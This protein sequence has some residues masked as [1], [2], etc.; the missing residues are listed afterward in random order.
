MLLVI[1]IIQVLYKMLR[2]YA[3][4]QLILDNVNKTYDFQYFFTYN[5]GIL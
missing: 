1:W 4:C 2:H 3:N 5:L